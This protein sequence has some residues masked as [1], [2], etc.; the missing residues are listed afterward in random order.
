MSSIIHED[1]DKLVVHEL[2]GR[3]VSIVSMKTDGNVSL[4]YEE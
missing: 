2:L 4:P 1:R 3:G